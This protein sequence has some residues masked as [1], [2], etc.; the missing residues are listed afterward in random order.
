M[1]ADDEA[2]AQGDDG[3]EGGD[4]AAVSASRAQSTIKFPY[5]ALDEAA[6]VAKTMWNTYSGSCEVNQLAATLDNRA[7]SGAFR[8][9]VTS[10]K[11]FG[12]VEGRQGE[13]Q[14]T[15]LGRQVVDDRTEKQALVDAFLKVPLYSAIFDEAQQS[16]G[17][18]PNNDKG[19]EEMMIRLGVLPN[20]SDRARRAFQRSARVAGFQQHGANRLV[21][22]AL[23]AATHHE[24]VQEEHDD[25]IEPDKPISVSAHPLMVGLL[26]SLPPVGQSFPSEARKRWLNAVRVNFDFIYGPQDEIVD[27]PA[28]RPQQERGG[29][30]DAE[31]PF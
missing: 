3:A 2:T 7:T 27:E 30:D 11:L 31:E 25:E 4:D 15:S 18:L 13:L 23:G 21:R 9:K 12:L 29:L 10:L 20:Q 22:P 17:N 19:L 26:Q 5:V 1:D 16:G 6:S 14:L 28:E 24:E 8:V